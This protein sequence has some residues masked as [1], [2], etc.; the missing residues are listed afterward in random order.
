MPQ[1][2]QLRPASQGSA[3]GD[4]VL[5]RV[6]AV[7]GDDSPAPA[8]VAGPTAPRAAARAVTPDGISTNRIAVA[9]SAARR[10][11]TRSSPDERN[12]MFQNRQ[13]GA[14]PRGPLERAP[15]RASIAVPIQVLI[16]V[17]VPLPDADSPARDTGNS[18]RDGAGDH[19]PFVAMPGPNANA[20]IARPPAGMP[21]R[22]NGPGDIRAGRTA[23]SPSKDSGA[24]AAA[25]K[26]LAPRLIV[27]HA[28]RSP[29]EL[30]LPKVKS[31]REASTSLR[32]A[33]IAAA[34][35]PGRPLP[36]G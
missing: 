17:P 24:R 31:R 26:S 11:T 35:S 9:A 6:K 34:S 29:R 12:K 3:R 32:D 5:S 30:E 33:F 19:L 1:R 13:L 14:G 22:N 36:S 2:R 4:D 23:R 8:C 27:D 18:G 7:L 20:A 15:P 16:A 28:D 25:G 10:Q 21:D